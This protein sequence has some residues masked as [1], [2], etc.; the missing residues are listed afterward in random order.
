MASKT[1]KKRGKKPAPRAQPKQERSRRRHDSIVDAAAESFAEFGFDATTMDGIAATAGTSIGSVYQFF[2]NKLAVFR[3]V[4]RRAIESSGTTFASLMLPSSDKPWQQ[5][6]DEAC[7]LFF[8]L[9]H[10]DVRMRATV[11]N[12]QLYREYE[13][14]DSAQMEQFIQIVGALIGTW[15]TELPPERAT[16][17]A[18][19]V[20]YT[21]G[22]SLLLIARESPEVGRV[23]LE[24]TKLMVR[25]YLEA[26]V[27]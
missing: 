22:M 14:E 2:P 16:L 18:R 21:I 13:A 9:H 19:T 23:Q 1:T 26:Y 12:F 10:R 5:I 4:A 6:L 24:E 20:V 17:V 7:D 11:R 25:R 15:A 3:E 27:S 8:E